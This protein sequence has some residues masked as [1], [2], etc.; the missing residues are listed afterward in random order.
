MGVLVGEWVFGF[1]SRCLGC[2]V[3]VWNGEWVFGLGSGCLGW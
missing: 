3:G 2:G 1:L